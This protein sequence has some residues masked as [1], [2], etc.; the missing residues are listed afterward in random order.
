MR[1][2]ERDSLQGHVVVGQGVMPTERGMFRLDTMRVGSEHW[3]RL[4]R[5]QAGLGTR[6]W[7][8]MSHPWKC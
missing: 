5:E 7:M 4:P 3:T 8:W 1:N 6:L 2:L